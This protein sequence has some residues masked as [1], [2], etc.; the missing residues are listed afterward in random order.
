LILVVYGG[1]VAEKVGNQK[2]INFLASSKYFC[3]TQLY[4]TTN[5]V[6]KKN[7]KTELN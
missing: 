6:A 5:V 4:F 2:I 1:N 7:T 3:I